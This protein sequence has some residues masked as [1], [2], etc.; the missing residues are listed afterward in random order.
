MFWVLHRFKEVYQFKL[1]SAI[2]LIYAYGFYRV[3]SL[4]DL[5]DLLQ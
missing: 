5:T 3:E 2:S 4:Q 1:S